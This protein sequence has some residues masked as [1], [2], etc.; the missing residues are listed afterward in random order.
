MGSIQKKSGS[1]SS[2]VRWFGFK[3]NQSNASILFIIGLL[4]LLGT[5]LWLFFLVSGLINYSSV[6]AAYNE[7]TG[8]LYGYYASSGMSY[9]I[10][11]IVL[12]LILLAIEVYTIGRARKVQKR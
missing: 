11:Y 12:A 2:S 9:Y 10:M 8:G 5:S 6:L 4:G 3:L 7:A 1:S